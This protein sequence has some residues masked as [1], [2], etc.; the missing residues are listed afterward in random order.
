MKKLILISLVIFF[1]ICSRSWALPECE[2][3]PARYGSSIVDDWNNCIGTATGISTWHSDAKYIGEFKNGEPD[4]YGTSFFGNEKYVGMHKENEYY[5]QGTF[6]NSDGSVWEGQ[7]GI[8]FW[9]YDKYLKK[10]PPG[11][12]Q[13]IQAQKEAQKKRAEIEEEK[14]IRKLKKKRIEE[15]LRL[16]QQAKQKQLELERENIRRNQEQDARKKEYA[17]AKEQEDLGNYELALEW[18]QKC[19]A[20]YKLCRDN[21]TKLKSNKQNTNETNKE[22]NKKIIAKPKLKPKSQSQSSNLP[23]CYN[24]P[25]INQSIYYWND[26]NGSFTYKG[27]DKY[28]GEFKDNKNHGNGTYIWTSGRRY[29]GEWKDGKRHGQGTATLPDGRIAYSGKWIKDKTIS[30]FDADRIKEEQRITNEKRRKQQRID[31]EKRRE[32][33][34]IEE[35]KRIEQQ[36]IE[37]QRIEKQQRIEAA[38]KEREQRRLNK[39]FFDTCFVDVYEKNIDM[40]KKDR[41]LK[42]DARYLCEQLLKS[43]NPIY[44]NCLIS[45]GS[46]KDSE[47]IASAVNLCT[48][49]AKNPSAL[50]KIKYMNKLPNFLRKYIK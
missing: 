24:S 41:W 32:Q 22:S 45:K 36:R 14:R 23:I 7:W 1:V 9:E 27:G 16:K 40:N 18:Y 49:I 6:F 50:D 48:N 20:S 28:I 19:Y 13:R 5:G 25:N 30:A 10:Y 37:Q 21:I 47:L 34:R 3:S 31:A 17:Y 4:G 11:E 12:Y 8:D 43:S 39:L 29:E 38:N 44:V 46:N 35:T 33:L 15:S 2:G 26:C 42:S